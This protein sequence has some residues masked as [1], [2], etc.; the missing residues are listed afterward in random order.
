[1]GNELR[2]L[3]GSEVQV[4]GGRRVA[5]QGPQDAFPILWNT[6]QEAVV[7]PV[8]AI[9]ERGGERSDETREII[10][11]VTPRQADILSDI[12]QLAFLWL[13]FPRSKPPGAE[14]DRSCQCRRWINNDFL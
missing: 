14:L 6:Q 7:P 2:N 13:H 4:F 8:P 1:M 3:E 11:R 5:I 12:V 10:S 9:P